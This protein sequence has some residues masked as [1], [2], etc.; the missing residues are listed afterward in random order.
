MHEIAAR[1][2]AHGQW[3]LDEQELSFLF[4]ARL[5]PLHRKGKLVQADSREGRPLFW[6]PGRPVPWVAVGPLGPRSSQ[7]PQS[8]S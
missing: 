8:L 2:R 1:G 7:A 6:G 5:V 3:P 4:Q